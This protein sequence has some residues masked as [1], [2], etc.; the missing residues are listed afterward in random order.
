MRKRIKKKLA[1]IIANRIKKNKEKA[2]VKELMLKI[3]NEE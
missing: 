2:L 1:N 3:K